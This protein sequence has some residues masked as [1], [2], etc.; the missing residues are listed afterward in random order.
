[1]I[2]QSVSVSAAILFYFFFSTSVQFQV[3]SGDP[4]DLADAYD[5]KEFYM[6]LIKGEKYLNETCWDMTLPD[7]DPN[8]RKLYDILRPFAGKSPSD[9]KKYFDETSSNPDGELTNLTKMFHALYTNGPE[10]YK[11]FSYG[12]PYFRLCRY[13]YGTVCDIDAGNEEGV[14]VSCEEDEVRK[15]LSGP[16]EAINDISRSY[17]YDKTI[18][19]EPTPLTPK[20]VKHLRDIVK[21]VLTSD[22]E[23]EGGSCDSDLSSEVVNK[24]GRLIDEDFEESTQWMKT[25]FANLSDVLRVT[26]RIYWN[27][28]KICAGMRG[29]VCIPDRIH[30]EESSSV[31]GKCKL[32]S[33]V[34][35]NG[36]VPQKFTSVCTNY[37]TNWMR[38]NVSDK[39]VYKDDDSKGILILGYTTTN[40]LLAFLSTLLM[41]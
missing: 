27:E 26:S 12:G 9:I 39:S 41:N 10:K 20:G 33:E 30:G 34:I 3:T 13:N 38:R 22:G 16:C 18:R 17:D 4:A 25:E 2:G 36:T 21:N 37:I 29:L 31:K 5:L 14:C 35:R 8:G 19:L 15:K 32:C 6:K 23:K 28:R 11:P 24:Y 1:M 7:S 40:M